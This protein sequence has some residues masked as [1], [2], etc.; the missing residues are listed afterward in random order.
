MEEKATFSPAIFPRLF[1]FF[2]LKKIFFFFNVEKSRETLVLIGIFLILK[3][4]KFAFKK[5]EKKYLKKNVDF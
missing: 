4:E 3:M 2:F 1:F 5:C